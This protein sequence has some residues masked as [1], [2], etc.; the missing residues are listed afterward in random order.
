MNSENDFAE[1]YR[2]SVGKEVTLK[3]YSEEEMNKIRSDIEDS[4]AMI[5]KI[6]GYMND[7]TFMKVELGAHKEIFQKLEDIY[8]HLVFRLPKEDQN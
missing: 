1:E 2:E 7:L 6:H 4:K 3:T 8:N 5:D